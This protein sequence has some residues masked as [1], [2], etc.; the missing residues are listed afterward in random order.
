KFITGTLAA[1]ESRDVAQF[2]ANP[3]G[4]SNQVILRDANV[5]LN[6][7]PEQ[8]WRDGAPRNP[9]GALLPTRLGGPDVVNNFTNRRDSNRRQV[10]LLQAPQ[11]TQAL[12]DIVPGW[13]AYIAVKAGEW[14]WCISRD[15]IVDDADNP[16]GQDD[17]VV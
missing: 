14:V 2:D 13:Y 10:R 5:G 17:V 15:N 8:Q 9:D 6:V 12:V 7:S 1:L 16:I 4:R 3:V 11:A